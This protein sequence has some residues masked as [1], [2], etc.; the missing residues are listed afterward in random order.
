MCDLPIQTKMITFA[1]VLGDAWV[2][3][4]SISSRYILVT[5]LYR[6]G[7]SLEILQW[8]G[9]LWFQWGQE[10]TRVL[11]FKKY[12]TSP[13]DASWR[14]LSGPCHTEHGCAWLVLRS[15][16]LTMGSQPPS[17][18]FVAQGDS[19]PLTWFPDLNQ[20]RG[21]ASLER[22]I[23]VNLSKGFFQNIQ[24]WDVN[25]L[26][27]FPKVPFSR[28]PGNPLLGKDKYPCIF[29]VIGVY[30]LCETSGGLIFEGYI[31]G[32][33]TS[34]TSPC[35]TTTITANSFPGRIPSKRRTR[36]RKNSSRCALKPRSV[37]WSPGGG[38]A[39][40]GVLK[41]LE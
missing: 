12:D 5:V 33:T 30:C 39:G 15:L 7:C 1:K 18:W 27:D 28:L 41:G 23:W 35:W 40:G 36:G 4:A 38:R 22:E 13:P 2:C 6:Q 31:P 17:S 21:P 8:R 32:M 20:F 14:L 3:G 24:P 25:L 37:W 26:L 19:W 10:D 11:E 29:Q 9:I 34:C 16:G